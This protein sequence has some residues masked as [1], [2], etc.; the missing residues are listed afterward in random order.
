MDRLAVLVSKPFEIVPQREA[1]VGHGVH[2]VRI[3]TGMAH[4]NTIRYDWL[5]YLERTQQ[6]TVKEI[7]LI[8][9]HDCAQS[10]IDQMIRLRYYIDYYCLVGGCFMTTVQNW[11]CVRY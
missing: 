5:R 3:T 1:D 10:T 2:V 7:I 11:R 4:S 9:E 6:R 8:K